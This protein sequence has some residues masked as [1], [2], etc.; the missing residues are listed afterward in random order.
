MLSRALCVAIGVCSAILCA[1]TPVLAAA[2]PL[3]VVATIF[4][5]AD[6]VHQIGKEHVEV[7]T[8]L[9]SGASPHTF[10]PTP[11]QVRDLAHAEVFVCV[12]AGLDGWAAKLLAARAGG[13]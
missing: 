3:K 8:L 13:K 4:P 1:A 2:A 10:E 7:V 11:S 6:L 5:L 9:P 12:G